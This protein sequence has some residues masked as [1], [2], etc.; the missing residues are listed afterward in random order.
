[1][2]LLCP[3]GSGEVLL[4]SILAG[5]FL[6][7][8]VPE[9]SIIDAGANNGEESCFVAQFGRVVHAIEPLN[10]NVAHIRRT[11]SESHPNLRPQLGGLGSADGVDVISPT[12]ALAELA[13]AAQNKSAKAGQYQLNWQY[14]SIQR[15]VTSR[16]GGAAAQGEKY[17]FPVW[18]VDTLFSREWQG[19]RLGL[20]H[21]DVEGMELEVLLG[22]NATLTRDAPIITVEVWVHTRAAA[23]RR[24]ME[25]LGRIGYDAYLIEEVAGWPLDVRNLLCLPRTRRMHL[26]PSPTLD[27]AVSARRLFA[28]DEASIFE[29]AYPCCRRGGACCTKRQTCCL[30]AA[31]VRRWLDTAATPAQRMAASA[32]RQGSEAAGFRWRAHGELAQLNGS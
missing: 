28:V 19:E 14:K 4:H 31:A 27:L 16:S 26:R 6:E 7:G 9:G 20:A 10:I 13:A 25:H 21:L 5:L 32:L 15:S 18:R 23:T 2:P 1:M 22:A 11:Y 24:L 30:D 3:L 17:S 8:L 29:L 12:S